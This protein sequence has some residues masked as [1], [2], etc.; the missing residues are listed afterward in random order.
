MTYDK[1]IADLEAA[2]KGSRELSDDILRALGWRDNPRDFKWF[3]P[4]GKLHDGRDAYNRRLGPPRPSPT[5]SLDA[6]MGLL[7]ETACNFHLFNFIGHGVEGFPETAWACGFSDTAQLMGKRAASE[8]I[9]RMRCEMP[10]LF[11]NDL[12]GPPILKL[13]KAIAD[14]FIEFNCPCAAIP[15]LAI[16]IASLYARKEIDK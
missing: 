13:E 5:E 7:P 3:D 1:L 14:H 15:A 2:P 10:S 12:I 9:E 4:D 6:A 16:C 8:E 11:S